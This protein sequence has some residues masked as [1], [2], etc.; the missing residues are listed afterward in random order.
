MFPSFG[1]AQAMDKGPELDASQ[2]YYAVLTTSMGTIYLDLFEDKTPGTVR[3]FVNLAEGTGEFRHPATGKPAKEP[4]YNGS[5]FHRVIPEFM[6][7]T[8]VHKDG[9]P[10]NS[11]KSGPGYTIKDEILPT[12]KFDAPGKLGLA[13][14]PQPNTG[15]GQFFITEKSTPWLDGQ[16]TLFGE[17]VKGTDGAEVVKKMARV[18]RGRNDIPTEPITLQ[19]VEIV[20]VPKGSDEATIKEKLGLSGAA[21]PAA[22]TAAPTTEA[23]KP[24]D[25]Q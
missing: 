25:A 22:T 3:N 6:V 17:V 12:L 14:L 9:D 1:K 18:N 19:K 15:G 8:G 7:Q 23:P 13:R 4:Y 24:P 10:F 11:E 16:Y 5:K 21:K 2:D 20:R